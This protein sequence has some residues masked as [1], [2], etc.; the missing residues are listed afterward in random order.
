MVDVVVKH[1]IFLDILQGEIAAIFGIDGL[2]RRTG[3]RTD[4]SRFVAD[5]MG[6]AIAY[7]G[8]R[9][10]HEVSSNRDLVTHCAGHDEQC[11]FVVGALG[12]IGLEV[13][14]HRV[15]TE[16]IVKERCLS[17]RFEH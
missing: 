13:V 17:D 6:T 7:H 16:D 9:R 5:D 4:S 3:Q 1:C 15:F 8:I 12:Y 10:L 2:D 14:C 11:I